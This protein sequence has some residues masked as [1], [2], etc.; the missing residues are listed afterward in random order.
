[1]LGL[2]ESR[3]LSFEEH[4]VTHPSANPRQHPLLLP[5]GT[6]CSPLPGHKTQGAYS[7][8]SFYKEL[9]FLSGSLQSLK[10][11]KAVNSPWRGKDG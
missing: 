11:E 6:G 5:G 2:T 1:M 4:V 10:N 3:H 7:V 8:T 9:D